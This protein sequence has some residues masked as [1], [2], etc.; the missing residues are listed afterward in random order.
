MQR[1]SPEEAAKLQGF[2]L[3]QE[4]ANA[5]VNVLINVAAFVLI[6]GALRIGLSYLVPWVCTCTYL[7]SNNCILQ[8]L[9][10]GDI[11]PVLCKEPQWISYHIMYCSPCSLLSYVLVYTIKQLN[12]DIKD[13]IT[14]VHIVGSMYVLLLKRF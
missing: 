13:T 5:R 3:E 1:M 11:S 4:K 14:S 7:T 12:I 6:V 10:L 9:L 8:V 2:D